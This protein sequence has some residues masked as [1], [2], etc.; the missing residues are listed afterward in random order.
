[1]RTRSTFLAL[2]I[3]PVAALASPTT[4]T[5]AEWWATVT[6]NDVYV[7]SAPSVD[8]A[9]PFLK[10]DRD[11][12]VKVV[13]ENLGWARVP[14]VGPAFKGAFGYVKADRKLKVAADGKTAEVVTRADVLAPNLPA[15]FSP[16]SS[17]KAIGKLE[18]GQTVVILDTIEGQRDTVHKIALPS[19]ADGW[20]NLTFLRRSSA[21]ELAKLDP[22]LVGG[23]AATGAPAG[24]PQPAT[25]PAGQPSTPPAT[26]N[27]A[28]SVTA[29]TTV[30]PDETTP[31]AA[32]GAG[33]AAGSTGAAP[34]TPPATR[35]ADGVS[36]GTSTNVVRNVNGARPSGGR[37]AT[38][39]TGN[40]DGTATVTP[41]DPSQVPPAP[42]APRL[43]QVTMADIE[44]AFERLKL[45]N[46]ETAEVGPLRQRYL[47]FA[48]RPTTSAG[49]REFA[50]ARAE[51]L[52]IKEEIQARL[53]E[54]KSLIAK[55]NADLEVIRGSRV[56][57]DARQPYIAVGRLNASTIYD[58][59]R[60]PLLFR[61]QDTTGGQ[62]IGYLQP[63]QGFDL[64]ALLGQLVGIVGTKGYDDALRL[65]IIAP[66]RIDVLTKAKP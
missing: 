2:L 16:D 29:T 55:S 44:A 46:P 15:R 26:T 36:I 6:A 54:V 7:R 56:A 39:I 63:G 23:G 41:L 8:S 37:S 33:E 24:N 3:A 17:W 51:Q 9:Y 62:T 32:S 58:G 14:T 61:I 19:N 28:P 47:E 30:V 43:D 53:A 5:A 45:E 13:E 40:P 21:D 60:L 52:K 38:L 65:N 48:D 35:T 12:M 42:A 31:A 27:G 25:T 50:R 57:M 66:S 18:P 64:T 20:I 22:A 1:M 11:A 49:Q 59:V 34:P 10:L 4:A